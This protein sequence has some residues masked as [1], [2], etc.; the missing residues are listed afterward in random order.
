[1]HYNLGLSLQQQ[2]KF[3]EAIREYRIAV[4]AKPD[5]VQGHNNLAIVLFLEGD[6]AGSWKEVHACRQLGMNP[7]PDFVHA[8]SEKMP[9]PGK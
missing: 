6:Y 2:G 7:H 3:K 4:Q 1:M 9:D 5:L 8:L